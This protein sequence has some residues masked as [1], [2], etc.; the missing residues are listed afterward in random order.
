MGCPIRTSP[1]RCLFTSS[2]GLFAGYR[3]LHRLSTPRHPPCALVDRSHQPDDTLGIPLCTTG[4]CRSIRLPGLPH[5]GSPA[6]AGDDPDHINNCSSISV[7]FLQHTTPPPRQ[8][9]ADTR[10]TPRR[11]AGGEDVHS[12]IRLSKTPP[13]AHCPSSGGP[14]VRD[15]RRPGLLPPGFHP[16]K[17]GAFPWVDLPSRGGSLDTTPRQ[18]R[19]WK[20]SGSTWGG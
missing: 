1:D 5:R 4:A 11:P 17:S 13:Q 9:A 3:V 19:R 16:R 14:A 7:F 18:S 10:P 12:R 6:K 20:S 2:P 15:C 8:P